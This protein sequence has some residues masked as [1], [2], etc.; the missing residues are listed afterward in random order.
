MPERKTIKILLIEDN[1]Y[2]AELLSNCIEKHF[3]PVKII[4]AE[5]IEI[6]LDLMRHEAFQ[7]IIID[8]FLNGQS[9]ISQLSHIK[10]CSTNAPIAVISGSGDEELAVE[11][12]KNGASEYISK[13]KESLDTLHIYI[14]N[15]LKTK[16]INIKRPTRQTPNTMPEKP[17][18]QQATSSIKDLDSYIKKIKTLRKQLHDTDH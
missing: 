16:P 2:H 8:S 12:I 6:A 14:A 11:A 17:P 9:T 13:T 5:S 18:I 1:P 4:T 7:L 15:L 3:S 10:T